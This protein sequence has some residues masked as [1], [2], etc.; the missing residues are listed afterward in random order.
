MY[1][2]SEK[3]LFIKRGYIAVRRQLLFS[4]RDEKLEITQLFISLS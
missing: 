2:E 1:V 3:Y 4:L